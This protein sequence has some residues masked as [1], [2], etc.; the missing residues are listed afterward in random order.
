MKMLHRLWDDEAGFIV[1]AEL[2]LIATIVVVGL[3]VGLVSL[4]NQV[5]QELVDAG[6]AIGSLS[7]GFA[8]S[9]TAQPG[10]A[11]TDGSGYVDHIDFGQS[12]QQ[13][14]NEPG[15]ISVSMLPAGAPTTSPGG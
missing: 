10:V 15:G 4:R 11:W 6:Q 3:S 5:V 13:P 8:F 12:P 9:G 1:S 14:G 2:V 7:Q